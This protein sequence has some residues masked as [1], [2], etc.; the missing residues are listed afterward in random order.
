[1]SLGAAGVTLSGRASDCIINEAR[2]IAL[3]AVSKH[4]DALEDAAKDLEEDREI[5]RDALSQVE[6]FWKVQRGIRR[7]LVGSL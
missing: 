7:R 5:A 2:E 3:A 1:M 6:M 4:G